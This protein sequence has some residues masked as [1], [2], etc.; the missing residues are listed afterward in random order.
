M[1]AAILARASSYAVVDSVPSVCTERDTLA[2][3]RSWYARMTSSTCTGFCEVL[4][5]SR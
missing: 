2:L 3:C 5:L 4:A 1:N